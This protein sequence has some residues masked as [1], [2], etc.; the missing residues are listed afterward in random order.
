LVLMQ[1]GGTDGQCPSD[2]PYRATI[3]EVQFEAIA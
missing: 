1:E 2:L 3:T